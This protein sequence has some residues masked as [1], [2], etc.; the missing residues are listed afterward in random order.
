MG[1]TVDGLVSGLDTT[2]IIEAYVAV[3]GAST[4]TL[5]EQQSDLETRRSLL[6]SFNSLLEDIQTV[7]SDYAEPAD[8]RLVTANSTDEDVLTVSA[9]TGGQPGTFDIEVFQLAQ[10]EM[11]VSNGFDSD[12]DDVFTGGSLSISV[13][14]ELPATQIDIDAASGNTSLS[15]LANYISDNIDGVQAYVLDDGADSANHHL[16]VVSESTG[17]SQTIDLDTALL[18]GDAL[19]FTEQIS[20][21]DAHLTL[22]G[23]DVYSESNTF[24]DV[25]PGLTF[26]AKSEGSSIVSVARDTEGVV[27]AVQTF[28]DAYNQAMSFIDSYSGLDANDNA[29]ALSGESVLRSVQAAL[30]SAM[31]GSYA[32]G[33]LQGASILGLSTEQDGSLALDTEKLTT[34][35]VDHG[36]DAMMILAGPD[37]IFQSLDGR[38]D[39]I[40]D[41]DEGTIA[42]R[43][44]S[45]D[46]Q[47]ESFEEQIA[48]DEAR[49][50][51]YED[52]LRQQFTN[53]EMTLAELQSMSSF[54]TSLFSST[55]GGASE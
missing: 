35:L 2:S 19:S 30:Q 40:V 41:P 36:Q 31:A 15:G 24:T 46:D 10:S 52:T 42:M 21:Q 22:A 25:V 32:A 43:T 27:G 49:L 16:V 51:T 53:L 44:E 8:L 11:E 9:A 23:L 28:V 6:Q 54:V 14:G 18:E 55:L 17:S 48:A 13:A 45:L 4:D 20:A 5:R 3:A 37:G 26:E 33:E 29:S 12:T 7:V 38:L 39:V 50:E 34:A 47:I 1:V